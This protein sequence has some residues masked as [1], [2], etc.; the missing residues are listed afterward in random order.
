LA[1]LAA[2]PEYSIGVSG[3]GISQG[4]LEEIGESLDGDFVSSI[5]NVSL[6]TGVSV[7]VPIHE[8]ENGR[9]CDTAMCIE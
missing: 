4:Y 3:G 6:S 9:I 2:F 1:D 5:S 8:R 7:L